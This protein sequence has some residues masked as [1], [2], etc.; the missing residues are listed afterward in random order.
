MNWLTL[1]KEFG[2]IGVIFGA[3]FTLLFF[4]VKWTLSTTK[5]IL[6]QAASERKVWQEI[7]V[8]L[9]STMDNQVLRAQEFYNQTNEAHKYQ[10]S[11]H[12]KMIDNLQEQGKVLARINGK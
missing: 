2:L 1:F 5:D 12:E 8:K 11:E 6:N 9:N 4:I 3:I 10:R 7:V